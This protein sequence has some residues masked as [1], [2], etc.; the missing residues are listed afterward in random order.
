MDLVTDPLRRSPA[1]ALDVVALS[2]WAT[3]TAPRRLAVVQR[4]NRRAAVELAAQGS[5]DFVEPFRRSWVVSIAATRPRVAVDYTS[6]GG[7]WP[8]GQ[9]WA[10]LR[11]VTFACT[12]GPGHTGRHA[13][14]TKHQV[15]A[16]WGDR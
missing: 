9:E 13:A 12:R 15:V 7:R 11:G 6:T 3:A 1:D 5:V 8:C 10:A 2:A 14:G 4:A 16:V